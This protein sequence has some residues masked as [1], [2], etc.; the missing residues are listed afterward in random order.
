MNWLRHRHSFVCFIFCQATA[1]VIYLMSFFVSLLARGEEPISGIRVEQLADRWGDISFFQQLYATNALAF[2]RHVEDLVRTQAL[3][4]PDK[5]TN[6]IFWASAELM[7]LASMPTVTQPSTESYPEYHHQVLADM[8]MSSLSQISSSKDLDGFLSFA[9]ILKAIRKQIV[10]GHVIMTCLYSSP[11]SNED[12]ARRIA[13][14]NE[15]TNFQLVIRK[16]ERKMLFA[17]FSHAHYAF[18]DVPSET[19]N[20]A[21][22]RIAETAELS[23]DELT[24]FLQFDKDRKLPEEHEF[25]KM[26]E[27]TEEEFNVFFHVKP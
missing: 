6:A 10:P 15:Q 22:G 8:A 9:T 25:R 14:R 12:L 7:L 11:M 16:T 4:N 1:S 18:S 20:S 5:G 27:P 19:R 2:K 13:E 21:L 3:K 24:A 23:S 17:L 26:R